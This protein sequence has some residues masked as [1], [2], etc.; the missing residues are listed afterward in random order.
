MTGRG[1]GTTRAAGAAATET[2]QLR[3]HPRHA[4][5]AQAPHLGEQTWDESRQRGFL[6]DRFADVRWEAPKARAGMEATDDLYFD[7]LQQVRTSCWL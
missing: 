1:A 6:H 5:G 4:I 7:V 3:H 2:R